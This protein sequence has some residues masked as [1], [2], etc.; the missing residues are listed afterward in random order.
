MLDRRRLGGADG[1]LEMA[2]F[3]PMLSCTSL[4][5][6]SWL[7][8]SAEGR[9]CSG[10]VW[11]RQ[12]GLHS[13]DHFPSI[14]RGLGWVGGLSALGG[15]E[16][17]GTP[18]SFRG[19]AR[20]SIRCS[21]AS[22][23]ER[24]KS[25]GRCPPFPAFGRSGARDNRLSTTRGAATGSQPLMRIYGTRTH[26]P[27]TPRSYIL[28]SSIDLFPPCQNILSFSFYWNNTPCTSLD[29]IPSPYIAYLRQRNHG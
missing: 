23:A 15:S 27:Q 29:R 28:T 26:L 6:G 3:S 10:E 22:G 2:P 19:P 12:R 4:L 24:V 21:G 11:I 18:P 5:S 13:R 7:S 17:K 1:A 16:K 8:E 9:P 14:V 20:G 25:P